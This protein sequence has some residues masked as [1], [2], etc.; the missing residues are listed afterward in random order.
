MGMGGRG[1]GGTRGRGDRETRGQ[2]SR[3]NLFCV[4]HLRVSVSPRPRVSEY[5]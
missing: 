4:L 2:T 3:N 5:P 1:D